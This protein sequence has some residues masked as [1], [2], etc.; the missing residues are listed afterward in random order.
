MSPSSVP[1]VLVI[2]LTV[3]EMNLYGMNAKSAFYKGAVSRYSVI[4]CAF[5]RE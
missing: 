2:T 1:S 5:L 4:F 3:T